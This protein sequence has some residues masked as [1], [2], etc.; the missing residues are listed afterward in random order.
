M[1]QQE[2]VGAM[3]VACPTILKTY[4]GTSRIRNCQ[5]MKRQQEVVGAMVVAF[6]NILRTYRT[7]V[8]RS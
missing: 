7:G 5:L 1:L 4:R 2:V 8:P 6:P 3:V